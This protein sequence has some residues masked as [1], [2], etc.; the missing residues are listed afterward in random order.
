MNMASLFF[1]IILLTVSGHFLVENAAYLA[2]WLGLNELTIGLTVIAIGTSLPQLATS[3]WAAYKKQD[4]IAVGNILGSNIFN[5]L[6]VLIFP[7]IINPEAISHVLLW[8]DIPVMFA[9]TA[10]LLWFNYQE[11]RKI[12]RWQGGLL[13]LIYCCYVISLL[14]NAGLS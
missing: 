5:L 13:L 14:L 12:G 2:S 6:A 11:K 1:G 7:S 3:V 9:V 4:D 8:R 10:I